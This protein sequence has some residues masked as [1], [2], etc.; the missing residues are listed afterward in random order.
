MHHR[1]ATTTRLA[2]GLLAPTLAATACDIGSVDGDEDAVVCT[3]ALTITGTFTVQTPQPEEISG[4]WP[5]GLWTFT[6]AVAD[7][8]CAAAPTPLPQYQVRFERDLSSADPDYTWIGT[9]PTDP[10]D[11]FA[12]VSVSSGGGGLCEAELVVYSPTGET[13]WNLHP[14]L[15]ADG[16][17][18]GQ[19]DYDLHTVDQRPAP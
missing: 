4:C 15:Q 11:A 7:H 6:A 19:G 12:H 2:F 10:G 13:V 14:A 1:V 17:I 16:S 18:T 8:D 5:I 9:Y 3:A